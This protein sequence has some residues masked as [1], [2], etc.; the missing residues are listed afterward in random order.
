MLAFLAVFSL[1][2]SSACTV[3]ESKQEQESKVCFNNGCITVEIADTN[4]ERANGLMY[5][6]TLDKNRGMLFV[7]EQESIHPFWMKNTLIPLDIVWINSSRDV[8]Y[9]NRDTPP[10]KAE[11]CPLVN[12]GVK[13]LY[14]LEVNG[15]VADRLNLSVGE[16]ASI[17]M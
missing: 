9:I 7:F 10:C 2:V 8:V 16:R 13:A 6:E 11:P 12:P 1:V 3:D 17:L 14:V 15:G 4:Q 5:R